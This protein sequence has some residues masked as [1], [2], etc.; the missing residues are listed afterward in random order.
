MAHSKIR[1]DAGSRSWRFSRAQV[2]AFSAGSSWA[3]EL[4]QQLSSISTPGEFFYNGSATESWTHF[5]SGRGLKPSTV[6]TGR[7]SSTLSQVASH[8]LIFPV[9]VRRPESRARTPDSGP[10]CTESSEKSSRLSSS[11]KTPRTSPNEVSKSY[12]KTLRISGSMRNGVCSPRPRLVPLTKEDGCGWSLP[13]PTTAGN[14]HSPTM[15]HWRAHQNMSKLSGRVGGS[16]DPSFREW[17]LGLP[18]GWTALEPLEIAKFQ[19]WQRRHSRFYAE[20]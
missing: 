4:A 5:P 6:F 15:Q 7:V 13:T 1:T 12:S 18:I 20:G 9:P 17:M 19:Q 3:G 14:E 8:A 11:S 10:T 2:V 16:P